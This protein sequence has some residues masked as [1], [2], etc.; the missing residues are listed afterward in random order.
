MHPRRFRPA[1]HLVVLPA[2]LAGL[3]GPAAWPA[4]PRPPAESAGSAAG[5]IQVSMRDVVLYPY[6]DV[7]AAVASLTGRV[8]AEH[9][10]KPVVM[11]D[12]ASYR[13]ETDGAEMRLTAEGMTRLMNRHILPGGRTPIRQVEVGFNEGAI[14]MS[15]TMVKLGAPVPFTAT[16]RLEPTASGDLRVHITSM[17]AAGV[18]PKGLID[19]LGLQLDTLAQ[20]ANRGMFHIEGD[21]MIVP[22]ASMFPPPRFAGRL[23]SVRVTPQ[24]MVAVL[25]KP[26]T[27]AAP[28]VQAA[29]YIY[30]Q[31]G[32][33]SFAKLTMHDTDLVVVPEDASKPLAFSPTR[34]YAQLEAGHTEALPHFALAARVRDFASLGPERQLPR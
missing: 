20:P 22:V 24:G 7:P 31:G 17:R 18:I 23:A 33:L 26:A 14:S 2:V 32:T 15:G 16:A 8:V 9:P 27:P 30:F 34:Y 5:P 11:D 10:P 13:I 29:S 1:L 3:A 4:P 12:P 19:A 21:D 6:D 28:P 25:G